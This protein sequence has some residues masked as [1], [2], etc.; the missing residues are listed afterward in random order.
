VRFEFKSRIVSFCFSFSFV[1]FG[2]SCLL[3]LWCA[4]GRCSM[5]CSDEDHGRS[6]RPGAEDWGMATQVGYSVAERSR[7]QVAPCAVYTMH[8]ETSNASFLV[9]P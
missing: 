1:S 4:G 5:A 6:K 8:V 9:D 3:I 7:G 2:E